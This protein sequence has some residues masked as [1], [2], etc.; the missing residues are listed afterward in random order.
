M[1][2]IEVLNSG[3]IGVNREVRAKR[4]SFPLL[5]V[6]TTEYFFGHGRVS[7]FTCRVYLARECYDGEVLTAIRLNGLALSEKG[8]YTSVTSIDVNHEPVL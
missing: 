6:L 7:A 1:L 8:C 4:Y 2:V 5:S 3:I